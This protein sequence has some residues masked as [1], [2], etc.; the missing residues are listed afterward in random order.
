MPPVPE[1]PGLRDVLS[2]L[3]KKNNVTIDWDI[4][5]K[6]D[7]V[8]LSESSLL[9]MPVAQA[10][11]TVA[12]Q[13]QPGYAVKVE[14]EKAYH[15][16]RPISNAFT[17]TQLGS[18]L[19]DIATAADVPI[20]V[21]PNVT[22][23]VY[24]S[25]TNVPLDE[26]LQDVLAGKPYVVKKTPRYYQVASRTM[27]S[28]AF[29][30]VSETRRVRLNYS[31]AVR[32][33][34]M[35]A[36]VF[37]QYVQAEQ[38]NARDPND[39]GS[40][41][42]IT[43]VPALADRI[44]ADIK[45]IDRYKRHVMLDARVVS[46]EKGNLLNMGSQWSWPTLS[47]GTFTSH[48]IGTSTTA[49]TTATSGWPYGVQIGYAPDQTF[50][51]ALMMQLN[52]LVENTQADI[53]ANPT[54]VAQDGRRAEMRVIEEQWFMMQAQGASLYYTQAQ[55]Q[56]IESGTVL[57]ITPYIGDN[58]D[59]TLQMAVEVSDS[60][61]QARGSNLPLVTRRTAKNAV[62]VKD[63]GTVAVAGLTENRS[64]T[65][66]QK[67]PFLGDIPLIG[68]LFKNHNNDKSNREVAVFVT[69]HLV[70]EGTQPTN[71]LAEPAPVAATPEAAPDDFRRQLENS[72]R[73]GQ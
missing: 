59:I 26:A 24:V 65:D 68:G 46:M 51:N 48:G 73:K 50:T 43:A 23:D 64:R 36:P 17:G 49:G 19:Q 54:V 16:Y 37:A 29:L 70:A 56:K 27:S 2:D 62:T 60:V 69:A 44:E 5:V 6:N 28:P 34:Q 8:S 42:L 18:A 45:K 67:V 53:I 38:P 22:G 15:V 71:R 31:Q 40:V 66:E 12:T 21:D 25:F 10:V 33:K 4:T 3:A 35:L 63:G 58:N 32:V 1:G 20:V 57:T 52:L 30:D 61:P 39:Q 41:L 72:M 13:T 9:N 11:Q 47:A 55:L 7:P 14:N